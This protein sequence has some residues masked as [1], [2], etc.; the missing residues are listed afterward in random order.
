MNKETT[1]W[2]EQKMSLEGQNIESVWA[3]LKDV[4][5]SNRF[6][7][8]KEKIVEGSYSF[9]AICG[10]RTITT[11]LNLLP[12]IG[13]L[14]RLLPIGKRF[15]LEANVQNE[16]GSCNVA[17]QITPYMELFNS[18]EIFGFTQSIEERATDEY[19]A[20]RKLYKIGSSAESVEI[21]RFRQLAKLMI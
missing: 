13:R 7:I 9:S 1:G 18:E 11:A 3:A 12:I 20:A 16:N 6:R 17:L 5:L 14:T 10:L 8:D 4:V 2:F 19:F 21:F 15:F